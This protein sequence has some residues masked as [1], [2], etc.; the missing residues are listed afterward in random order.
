M[1][2][3]TKTSSSVLTIRFNQGD[4]LRKKFLS[5]E[6]RKYPIIRLNIKTLSS[7]SRIALKLPVLVV[8][9]FGVYVSVEKRIMKIIKSIIVHDMAMVKM[10]FTS[11]FFT[12]ERLGSTILVG[13]IFLNCCNG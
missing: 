3:A 9:Y 7:L 12:A 13:F 4:E 5:S 1:A 2:I 6:I 8:S 11:F 10:S